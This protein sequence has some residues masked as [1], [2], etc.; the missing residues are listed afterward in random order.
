MPPGKAK[1]YTDFYK[2]TETPMRSRPGAS[3]GPAS[4]GGSSKSGG[5]Q[6]SIPELSRDGGGRNRFTPGMNKGRPEPEEEKN[7]RKKALRR[8]LAMSRSK[9][10]KRKS[11]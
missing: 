8:R 6:R 4:G 5:P 2:N 1:G 7:P 11:S 9:T 10:F 3:Q